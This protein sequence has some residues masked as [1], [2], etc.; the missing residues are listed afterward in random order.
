MGVELERGSFAGLGLP[1][2]SSTLLE[3]VLVLT[4]LSEEV[5]QTGSSP[6]KHKKTP[7]IN[8]PKPQKTDIV[9]FP[10]QRL[11]PSKLMEHSKFLSS[12]LPFVPRLE[13]VS[14]TS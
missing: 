14:E 8:N 10:L 7:P 1:N 12:L 13:G 4:A 3:V 6:H 9:L 2:S 5:R 11:E